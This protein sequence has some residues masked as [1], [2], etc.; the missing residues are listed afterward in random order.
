MKRKIILCTV[1]CAV[2][3]SFS[4]CN[5]YDKPTDEV[6]TAITTTVST[7][8]V[9]TTAPVTTTQP[10][11]TT[12]SPT[13][14]DMPKDTTATTVMTKTETSTTPAKTSQTTTTTPK[15]TSKTTTTTKAIEKTPIEKA[16][17]KIEPIKAEYTSS[18]TAFACIE[19]VLKYYGYNSSQKDMVSYLKIDSE[20][21]EED[22]ELYGP[23]P[24]HFFVG[25]P[26]NTKYGSG[27][28]PIYEAFNLYKKDN[29]ININCEW[30]ANDIF[31]TLNYHF[32]KNN[33]V[34][35]WIGENVSYKVAYFDKLT[36]AGMRWPDNIRCMLLIGMT[37]NSLILSDPTTQST[38][39]MSKT[40]YEKSCFRQGLVI[41]N[42]DLSYININ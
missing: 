30:I 24:N 29:N 38:I 14:E 6:T 39:E 18:A 22:E 19:Q 16:K 15:K 36:K 21:Y 20:F 41:S 11:L 25:N 12:P 27:S 37:D 17:F 1:I 13:T 33:F 5:N 8:N 23:N 31:D 4:G 7:T 10:T 34:I 26:S 35:V 40:D 32:S 42:N 2:I 9:T 28:I 3:T